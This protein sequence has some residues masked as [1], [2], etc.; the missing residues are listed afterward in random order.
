[1]SGQVAAVA[2]KTAVS[3]G[4]GGPGPVSETGPAADSPPAHKEAEGAGSLTEG[5]IQSPDIA[6]E[7]E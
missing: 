7:G 2:G 5:R 6:T 3:T 4:E 1:M